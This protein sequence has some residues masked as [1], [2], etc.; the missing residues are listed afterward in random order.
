MARLR[1]I[2]MGTAAFA[3]PTLDAI[4]AAG[5][6]VPFV[7]TQPPRAAGRGLAPRPSPMHAAASR[8]GL[9]VRTPATLKDMAVQAEF[10]AVDADAAVVAAYGLLL[11]RPILEATRLGCL[12]VHPSLLPRWRGAAP[13]ARAI[14]AGDAT[15]G[16]MIMAMTEGL[17]SGPI[18]AGEEAPVPPDATTASLE[19]EL[20]L[21]GARLLV[22]T[23]DALARGEAKPRP[24]PSD[25]V[26]YARKLTRE[27]GRVDWNDPADL[28]ERRVRA[29]Q[30]W[31]GCHCAVG[32]ATVKIL[33]ASL[34]EGTG[35]PGT[36]L[37]GGF[38]VACGRGAL[39][40]DLVQREGRAA[41]EGAAFLRGARL[42]PGTRLG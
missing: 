37:E 35:P 27:E 11:P 18:L 7:Y 24:Q 40:L 33:R 30:P 39:R 19:P 6:A 26:T 34:A 2:V 21:R 36:V 29:F 17:D 12:N 1:V 9:A 32:G 8:H 42:A 20:A 10:A 28:I 14:E 4:V 38:V 25:G 13:V 16:V 3:V 22:A 23:L 5:H 41:T 31:P 15:T